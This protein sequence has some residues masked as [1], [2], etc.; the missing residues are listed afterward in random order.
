MPFWAPSSISRNDPRNVG[1]IATS[2]T[3]KRSKWIKS[4]AEFEV[5]KSI[6]NKL[7]VSVAPD[8]FLKRVR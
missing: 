1:R 2:S 5:D 8:G 7:L 6:D 3:K 4:H